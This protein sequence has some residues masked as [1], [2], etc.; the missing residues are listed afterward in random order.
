MLFVHTTEREEMKQKDKRPA[1]SMYFSNRGSVLT[2]RIPGIEQ[3]AALTRTLRSLF[4]SHISCV[5]MLRL[6]IVLASVV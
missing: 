3:V 2:R 5:R 6:M 1:P 4:V